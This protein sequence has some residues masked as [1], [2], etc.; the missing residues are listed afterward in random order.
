MRRQRSPSPLIA[1]LLALLFL[2]AQQAA[3]AHMIGHI[4]AAGVPTVVEGDTGHGAVDGL[5]DVC[6]TCVALAA[7]TG[8][9]P[10]PAAPAAPCVAAAIAE[11][12]PPALPVCP[13]AA[14]SPYLARAPPAVL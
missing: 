14:A 5:A 11:P 10:L 4:G 1:L 7:L 6:V 8:G 13:G 12:L 3:F 9:A 2:A